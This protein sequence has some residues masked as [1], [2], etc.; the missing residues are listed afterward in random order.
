MESFFKFLLKK[1]KDLLEL[2]AGHEAEMD[3]MD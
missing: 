3:E 2:R 1:S